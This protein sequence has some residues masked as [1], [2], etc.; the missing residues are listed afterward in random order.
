MVFKEEHN[1]CLFFFEEKIHQA[2][3]AAARAKKLQ[4]PRVSRQPVCLRETFACF[5]FVY[6][7]VLEH[8]IPVWAIYFNIHVSLMLI[9]NVS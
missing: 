7:F 4:K 9:Y 3:A 6:A 8:V 1:C 5:V 2:N